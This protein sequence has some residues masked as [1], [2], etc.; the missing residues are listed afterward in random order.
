[1]K[2]GTGVGT[3]DTPAHRHATSLAPIGLCRQYDALREMILGDRLQPETSVEPVEGSRAHLKHHQHAST[4]CNTFGIGSL[5][6]GIGEVCGRLACIPTKLRHDLLTEQ[7]ERGL[8]LLAREQAAVGQHEI[9]D[10]T[11]LE[12][13][14]VRRH[15]REPT[16]LRSLPGLASEHR[17]P[18]AAGAGG[19]AGQAPWDSSVPAGP[20]YT[21]WRAGT[22]AEI[23]P[24]P[25]H[26]SARHGPRTTPTTGRGP[27]RPAPRRIRRAHSLRVEPDGRPHLRHRAPA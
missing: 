10:A 15:L 11:G 18:G 19:A 4:L 6:V 9:P 1:M 22:V 13:R 14:E 5:R 7:A 16:R 2:G 27:A 24:A 25:G 26:P 3:A 23:P 20:R 21:G 8:R 17:P 12:Q